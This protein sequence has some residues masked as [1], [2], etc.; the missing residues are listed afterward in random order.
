M[1]VFHGSICEV[2]TPDLSRSKNNVDFGPGFYVTTIRHQA[3]RWAK[4]KS[5]RLGGEAVVTEVNM[6]E[7]WSEY[8]ETDIHNASA[9]AALLSFTRSYVVAR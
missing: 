2:Q 5:A 9:I 4:R 8:R 1:T 3:E 6:L 7:D